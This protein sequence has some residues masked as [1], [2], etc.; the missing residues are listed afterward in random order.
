MMSGVNLASQTTSR[1]RVAAAPA[2]ST[3]TDNAAAAAPPS[4][5]ARRM[6]ARSWKDPRLVVG[7]GLVAVSVL[8]GAR[9]LAAADDTVAVWSVRADLPAGA[10]V[11]AE[12]LVRE[13]VRFASPGMAARYVSAAAPLP[14]GMV[15]TR[16][17]TADELLPRASLTS[18][19]APE[20]V[21]VPVALA[22]DAVPATL[23]TGELVDVWV[24]PDQPG[25]E[26][27]RAV[28]VLEQVRVVAAPRGGGALGP[29]ATRQVVVGL[30]AEAEGRLGSALA[31]LAAG[32][33][34]MVR[35]G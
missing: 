23:R 17:V 20:L 6:S 9:V 18:D 12:D 35:R 15:L 24:T 30:P 22:S 33:A 16:D 13:D 25:G 34:V 28:R 1:A 2:A 5:P 7:V 3:A 21:E 14:D 10:T 11:E 19:A 26:V 32:S 8:V 31:K 4:P 29:S 27:S